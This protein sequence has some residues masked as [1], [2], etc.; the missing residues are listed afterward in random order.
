MPIGSNG[1]LPSDLGDR[2]M[3]NKAAASAGVRLQFKSPPSRNVTHGNP[4]DRNVSN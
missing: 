4:V 1:P 3:S 2:M